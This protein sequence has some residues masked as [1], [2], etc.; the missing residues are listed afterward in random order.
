MVDKL[1]QLR[2]PATWVVL[3]A[4]V[5]ILLMGLI[6]L[7]AA[8]SATQLGSFS[9]SAHLY[10]HGLMSAFSIVVLALLV[11]SCVLWDRTPNARM[12]SLLAAIVVSVGI[13][14]MFLFILV[15]LAAPGDGLGKITGFF[16]DI[17]S[18]VIPVLAVLAL[19]KL[20]QGQPAPAA[21]PQLSQQHRAGYGQ[22]GY[23]QPP[24]FGA[25]QESRQQGYGPQPSWQPGQAAGASWNTAG[26]AASGAS[27]TD[28]GHPGEQ[29]GWDAV[30]QQQYG[31]PQQQDGQPQ[32][33]YGRSQHHGQPQQV[34]QYGQQYGQQDQPQQGQFPSGPAE[35]G[36]AESGPAEAA[37]VAAGS[38]DASGTDDAAGHGNWRPA[39]PPQPRTRN[40]AAEQ[41]SGQE[42]QWGQ[43]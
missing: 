6:N 9:A 8:S 36:Q 23:G 31:Q 41:D 20:Y 42:W 33:Q 10:G 7:A 27:A 24:D 37:A 22:Q 2:E 5:V 21:R 29:G 35:S 13:V 39:N 1:K 19:W 15:G 30:P 32:Q 38:S 18:L 34:Q 16:E 28:W 17:A 4:M 40:S 11:G 43:R 14:A 25:Q 26:A 12:L 3:G